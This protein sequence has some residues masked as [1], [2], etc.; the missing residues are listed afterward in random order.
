LAA[1]RFHHQWLP[2]ELLLEREL[3]GGEVEADLREKGHVTKRSGG[4]ATVNLV[5]RTPDGWDAASD[6]RRGG[7]PAGH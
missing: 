2:D 7:R 6:P 5:R 1:P 4:L 3:T